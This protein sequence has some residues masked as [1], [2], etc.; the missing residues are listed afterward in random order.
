MDLILER[1]MV[2]KWGLGVRF[3]QL[4]RN[5]AQADSGLLG[6]KEPMR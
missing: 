6:R 2:C 5:L 1:F 4:P 3:K